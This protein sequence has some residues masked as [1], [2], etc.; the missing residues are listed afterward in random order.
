[1]KKTFF[2]LLDL[3]I[4]TAL[5]AGGLKLRQQRQQE[6][7]GLRRLRSSSPTEKTA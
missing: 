7:E 4:L 3:L 6:L 5:V 2:Y 1:M